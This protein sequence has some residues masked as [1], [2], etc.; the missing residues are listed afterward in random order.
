VTGSVSSPNYTP[1]GT[2]TYT[3]IVTNI[4]PSNAVAAV[5]NDTVSSQVTSWT[6]TCVPTPGATCTGFTALTA[7]QFSYGDTV[8]IPPGFTLTIT[9]AAQI[10]LAATGSV[11]NTASISVPAGTTD[12]NTGNN[13]VTF[14]NNQ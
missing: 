13:S 11:T 10:S 6:V 12:P 9:I 4:G 1:G 7:P 14:A 3:Y 2:L 8:S 5:F